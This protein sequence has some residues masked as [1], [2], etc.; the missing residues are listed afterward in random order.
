MLASSPLKCS[1]AKLATSLPNSPRRSS[2]LHHVV[3]PA[4]SQ[5]QLAMSV[6]QPTSS[7]FLPR[8]TAGQKVNALGGYSQQESARFIGIMCAVLCPQMFLKL[9]ISTPIL[10]FT[11]G[12]GATAYQVNDLIL[13]NVGYLG[14]FGDST[15]GLNNNSASQP[16]QFPTVI[17]IFTAF[18]PF[19]KVVQRNLSTHQAIHSLT[20]P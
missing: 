5:T 20:T 17:I 11:A 18:S 2:H 1:H 3:H 13:H 6:C 16:Q 14:E 12:P 7:H 8:K 15:Y 4:T 19:P 10:M 9:P